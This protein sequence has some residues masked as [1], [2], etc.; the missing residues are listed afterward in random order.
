VNKFGKGKA[1]TTTFFA[2]QCLDS[3][4]K[5]ATIAQKR[6]ETKQHGN[7]AEMKKLFSVRC[8]PFVNLH[9]GSLFTWSTD[10]TFESAFLR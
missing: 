3:P 10:H 9:R 7:T 4:A 1:G 6:A 8:V 5:L 2:N